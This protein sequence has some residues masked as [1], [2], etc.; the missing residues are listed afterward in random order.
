VGQWGGNAGLPGPRLAR[1]GGQ[2]ETFEWLG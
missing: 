2:D 1:T